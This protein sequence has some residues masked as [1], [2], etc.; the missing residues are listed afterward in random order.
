MLYWHDMCQGQIILQLLSI[1]FLI[2]C[3]HYLMALTGEF[4]RDTQNVIPEIMELFPLFWIS[5]IVYQRVISWTVF[6]CNFPTVN[7]VL[8]IEVPDVYM[9]FFYVTLFTNILLKQNFTLVVLVEDGLINIKS[10][11]CQEISSPHHLW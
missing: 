10:L 11:V 4:L 9:L 5:K 6:N 2:W 8:N 7:L 1:P 3:T